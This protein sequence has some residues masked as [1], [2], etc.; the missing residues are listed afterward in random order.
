MDASDGPCEAGPLKSGSDCLSQAAFGLIGGSLAGA[1][2]L[3]P[4]GGSVARP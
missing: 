1:A 3:V 2:G 4:S